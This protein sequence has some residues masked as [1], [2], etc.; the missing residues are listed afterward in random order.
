LIGFDGFSDLIKSGSGVGYYLGINAFGGQFLKFC[1]ISGL[2][3]SN[4]FK[5]PS[6][7]LQLA[8]LVL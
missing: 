3:L 1:P 5:N 6:E 8:N 2:I 7:S 4:S